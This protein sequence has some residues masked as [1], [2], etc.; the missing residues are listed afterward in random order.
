M[1]ILRKLHD[2][3]RDVA[4][5][6]LG[7][8]GA[9]LSPSDAQD[10]DA[11]PRGIFEAY[12]RLLDKSAQDSDRPAIPVPAALRDEIL[13]LARSLCAQNAKALAQVQDWCADRR[14]RF[15]DLP[16]SDCPPETAYAELL[17]ILRAAG[18]VLDPGETPQDWTATLQAV[19]RA[20]KRPVSNLLYQASRQIDATE[21]PA[22]IDAMNERLRRFGLRVVEPFPQSYSL[23][24]P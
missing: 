19:A 6:G 9:A 7:I 1:D 18:L 2:K 10:H 22:W 20:Q 14:S 11:P 16:A 23:T 3:A 5:D 12:R 17:A 15:A 21:L 8:I 24:A 4:L 13:S